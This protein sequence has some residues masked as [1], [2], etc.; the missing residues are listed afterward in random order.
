MRGCGVTPCLGYD[1]KSRYLVTERVCDRATLVGRFGTFDDDALIRAA[2][3]LLCTFATVSNVLGAWTPDWSTARNWGLRRVEQPT[4]LEFPELAAQLA[5]PAIRVAVPA[6]EWVPTLYDL[7]YDRSHACK[8]IVH[9]RSALDYEDDY[10]PALRAERA[11]HDLMRETGPERMS[12][13][14]ASNV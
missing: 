1:A 4:R 11:A 8:F 12:G 9:V 3:V 2:V 10:E 6:G 13:S 14:G 7:S 5:L